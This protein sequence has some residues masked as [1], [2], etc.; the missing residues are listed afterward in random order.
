VGSPATFSGVLLLFVLFLVPSAPAVEESQSEQLQTA[1]TLCGFSSA[2]ENRARET[3][4]LLA[5]GHA[6][7]FVARAL[8]DVGVPDALT[9]GKLNQSSACVPLSQLADRIWGSE[10]G[11]RP[12]ASLGVRNLGVGFD[13]PAWVEK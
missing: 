13:A 9:N 4:T 12:E 10:G 2:A 6:R 1:A 3:V 11:S 8:V 5:Q 7:L